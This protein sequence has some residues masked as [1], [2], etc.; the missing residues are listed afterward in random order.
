MNKPFIFLVMLTMQLSF[1]QAQD[2]GLK[3]VTWIAPFKTYKLY[4]KDKLKIGLLNFVAGDKLLGFEAKS[5]NPEIKAKIVPSYS[6]TPEELSLKSKNC[7]SFTKIS[8]EGVY[9][10]ICDQGSVIQTFK[11]DQLTNKAQLLS[12]VKVEEALSSK[13]LKKCHSL[14]AIAAS[15]YAAALCAAATSSESQPELYLVAYNSSEPKK[16]Q[17]PVKIDLGVSKENLAKLRVTS[18]SNPTNLGFYVYIESAAPVSTSKIAVVE[19]IYEKD[20]QKLRNSISLSTSTFINEKESSAYKDYQLES[21]QSDSVFTYLTLINKNDKKAAIAAFLFKS[22][23]IQTKMSLSTVSTSAS[24]ETKILITEGYGLNR[25]GT[26]AVVENEKVSIGQLYQGKYTPIETQNL[27]SEKEEQTQIALAGNRVYIIK[28]DNDSTNI[29]MSTPKND[30]WEYFELPKAAGEVFIDRNTFV[31]DKHNLI[32]QN[33]E[34]LQFFFIGE[35]FLEVTLTDKIEEGK[36]HQIKVDVVSLDK[37]NPTRKSQTLKLTAFSNIF[38]GRNISDKIIKKTTAYA[39]D[40]SHQVPIFSQDLVG[41]AETFTASIDGAKVRVDWAR[42]LEVKIPKS[43]QIGTIEDLDFIGENSYYLNNGGKS[44]K[45]KFVQCDKDKDSKA[46]ECNPGVYYEYK[47]KKKDGGE[48]PAQDLNVIAAIRNTERIFLLTGTKSEGEGA[49]NSKVV[50][51]VI[52]A[53]NGLI[54]KEESQSLQATE[55][56]ITIRKGKVVAYV[57]GRAPNEPNESLWYLSAK[58]VE[59]KIL[60][61]NFGKTSSLPFPI[62]TKEI[63]FA[64]DSEEINFFLLSDCAE[65]GTADQ[66]LYQ[67]NSPEAYPQQVEEIATHELFNVKNAK[68]CT[69]NSQVHIFS[70]ENSL[71]F[72]IE[73]EQGRESKYIYDLETFGITQILDYGCNS[74]DGIVQLL[75]LKKGEN[76]GT[77][78]ITLF[79]ESKQNPAQRIHSI[80]KF[81]NN[82]ITKIATSFAS[83]KDDIITLGI[84]PSS[85]KLSAQLVNYDGPHF[86]IDASGVKEAGEKKLKIEMKTF[87]EHASYGPI[88]KEIS[89]EFISPIKKTNLKLKNDKKIELNLEKGEKTYKLDELFD[90]EGITGKIQLETKLGKEAIKVTNRVQEIDNFFMEERLGFI[91]YKKHGDYIFGWNGE[92]ASLLKKLS[93]MGWHT[94]YEFDK[95]KKARVDYKDAQ[96][97][98]FGDKFVVFARS[99]DPDSG[100]DYLEIFVEGEKEKFEL[101]AKTVIPEGWQGMFIERI[102]KDKVPDE[103]GMLFGMVGF[104]NEGEP[105]IFNTLVEYTPKSGDKEPILKIFS[106]THS[107][108]LSSKITSFS[109]VKLGDVIVTVSALLDSRTFFITAATYKVD[110]GLIAGFKNISTQFL[111][112]VDDAQRADDFS[113]AIIECGAGT[114]KLTIDCVI[115][116]S[117]VYSSTATLEFSEWDS[118]TRG[119]KLVKSRKNSEKPLYNIAGYEP[120]QVV[121]ESDF[122]VIQLKKRG[123]DNFVINRLLEETD[124]E[125]KEFDAILAVYKLSEKPEKAHSPF[126][127]ITPEDLGL[128]LLDSVFNFYPYLERAADNKTPPILYLNTPSTVKAYKFGDYALTVKDY[129]KLSP[130]KDKIKLSSFAGTKE[131]PL[132]AFFTS[133]TD[134]RKDEKEDETKT[135]TGDKPK[136]ED[137]KK[138]KKDMDTGVKWYLWVA[139]AAMFVL[140]FLILIAVIVAA[141]KANC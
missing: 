105:Q 49:Q 44:K 73:I 111:K 9:S 118:I 68:F 122:V 129:K 20:A 40:T 80:S 10:A 127:I 106:V 36:E 121:R 60:D 67:I 17:N 138:D 101:K 46:L 7:A 75:G 57:S 23:T 89:V 103:K 119:E 117:G 124:I 83:E 128:T 109:A 32:F 65:N 97:V 81:S 29:R 41:N 131:M 43:D 6:E 59:K 140:C 82:K 126:Y 11:I 64:P 31:Y 37:N 3:F 61:F 33:G 99:E 107:M 87:K 114:A 104:E 8:V 113:N 4:Y 141:F 92:G 35:P 123:A 98:P 56:I 70:T 84:E 28:I 34:K 125:K 91:S 137:Q 139:I 77:F 54:I 14:A 63:K 130:S 66:F 26:C 79:G 12:T 88:S 15:G 22:G 132:G 76:E 116:T 25:E 18:S 100:I 120:A 110:S 72:S 108:G 24:S 69:T 85:N 86:Y 5:D 135:D 19:V 27:G 16:F 134:P 51:T 53:N 2:P 96:F 1:I 39:G 48:L 136:E 74:A 78:L 71:A 45:V 21:V 52:N 115:A 47:P 38:S 93:E 102:E 30:D 133:D 90:F 94:L 50:F 62:C 55:G 58:I 112:V 95:A 13:K 42:N